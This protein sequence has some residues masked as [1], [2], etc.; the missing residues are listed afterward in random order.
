MFNFKRNL[1]IFA[2]VLLILFVVL[3]TFTPAQRAD[4]QERSV[5]QAEPQ[6]DISSSLTIGAS[7]PIPFQPVPILEEQIAQ[8][9]QESEEQPLR[10][11]L[12]AE[13]AIYSPG[14]PVIITWKLTGGNLA[15]RSSL[16]IIARPPDGVLPVNE[17]DV[18]ETDGSLVIS[19]KADTGAIV[20]KVLE[21]AQLPLNFTYEVVSNGTVLND[22]AI[23]IGAAL[24]TT[25]TGRETKINSSDNR[26]RVDVPSSSLRT[27]LLMDIRTPSP[28]ALRG[29]SLSW[30]PVEIIAVDANSQKNV[31]RFNTP[32]TISIQYDE[33]ELLG[34]D[35]SVLSIFYYDPELNDWFPMETQVDTKNNILTTKSDHLTVFDYKAN[36]WQSAMVPSV[37]AFKTSDFTGAGTYQIN[38]WTPPGPN[39]LQPSLT[40]SYNS[41]V[42]DESSAYTQSSWV[43]MGWDLD[44]GSVTRTL[45]GTD[46]DWADDSV[47]ISVAGVSS[48]LLRISYDGNIG[49]FNTAD[50][51]FIKV[52]SNDAAY[53]Y[54]AWTKDGTKYEF[55]ESTDNNYNQACATINNHT[56]RWNLK[57]VT[58]VHGNTINYTYYTEFKPGCV[59]EVAVYPATITYG[60][61]KYSIEF[62]REARTDYQTS[63][64]T[65]ASRTLYGTSRL[66][67]VLI[68]HNGA[69]VKRYALSYAPN[70]STN[71]YPNFNFSKG[72]KTLTLI[73][74]QEFGSDGTA[75]P[76]VTFTYGDSMHLTQVNNGQGGTVTM[77]YADWQYLDD[78]N[79]DIRTVGTVFQ[80]EDCKNGPGDSPTW[81]QLSGTVRCD[82]SML[83]QV[84]NAPA[85]AS[86]GERAIPQEMI[87]PSARYN[88][89]VNVRSISGTATASW[90]IRDTGSNQTT[91]LSASGITTTGGVQTQQ[92]LT[93][94]VTY[95]PNNVKLRLECS[96]C[97]F[98]SFD[99][100]QYVVLYRVTSRVVTVQ[101]T[102]LSSTYTYQY[103]NASP[104]T[105]D[106]SAAVAAAGSDLATLY[107]KKLREFRGHAMSMVTAPNNLTTATWFWQAD[108]LK[109]RPYN[110]LV[111]ERTF[112]D[113]M[114]AMNSN[115]V[116][117]GGTHTVAME[118]QKDFDYSIKSTNP[119]S[120]WNVSYSRSI[121]SIGSGQMAV[122]HIRLSGNNAQGIVGIAGGRGDAYIIIQNGTARLVSFRSDVTLLSS[123]NFLKDEWYG[124]AFFRSGGTTRARIWQLDNPN[125]Y[126]EATASNVDLTSPAKFYSKVYSGTMFLDSYFEGTPYSQTL[127]TYQGIVQYDE[128]ANNGIPDLTGPKISSS[129]NE[130][131][132]D[133]SITW[134]R[135]DA[136]ENRNYNGDATF[137]GTKQD[138]TYGSYG[139]LAQ[140]VESGN[141]GSGWVNYRKTEY[142]YNPNIT[143]YIVGLPA[144]QTLKD[145][146]NNLLG[147]TL[148]FY[149]YATANTTPPTKGALTMQRTWAG[150]TDYAQTSMTYDDYG[151]LETQSV[152]TEYGTATSS[153]P[154]DSK[155]T[156][157]TEY[158]QLGYNT[159]PVLVRNELG[160]E[161]Q[162]TYNYALGLPLSVKDANNVTTSATYDGFGRMKT[163]T[164]PGDTSPTLSVT[165]HDTRI[166]FQVDLVQQVDASSTIRLS[167]FYDGAGREIQTQTAAAVVNGSAQNIVV[168]TQYNNLGQV[169]KKTVPYTVAANTA[170]SFV[171][172]TF[173]Q[174]YTSMIYDAVGRVDTTTAPNQT[175]VSYSYA[176]LST[177]I[178]DPK[179]NPTTTIMDVWGRTV[180]VDAPAGPDVS[181]QYDVLNRLKFVYRGDYPNG[182][183]F[184]TQIEYD[185]LGRKLWMK[186]PDM[187][188]WEYKYDALGNLISQKDAKLQTTCL[189]YD[190]LN[191]LDGK[192]YSPTASCGTPLNF[193]V[194]FNYDEGTNGTGRRTSMEDVSGSAVWTY[195][196]RGRLSTETKTISGA[197]DPFIT[198]WQYNSGDLPIQMNYPDGETVVYAY[199]TDGTLKSLTSQTSSETYLNDMQYDEAG[200]LKLIE[201]GN[202]IIDK[203][204]NYFA[205]NTA[206]MGG[207]LQSTSV[208]STT[209]LQS[210]TYTYDRNGNVDTITDV[211]FGPQIQSF[212]YDALNRIT[213]A[214]ASGGTDGLYS[215]SYTYDSTGRLH[216]KNGVTYTY[217]NAAHKHAVTSLSNGNSY[218][219]DANGNMIFRNVDGQAFDLVYDEENRLTNVTAQ[220]VQVLPTPTP[221]L[222]VTATPS[223]TDT[224]TITN[225]PTFTASPT[226]TDTSTITASPTITDTPAIIDTPTDTPSPTATEPPTATN[227]PL[228]GATNTPYPPSAFVVSKTNDTND[229]ICNADCSL[230]EAIRAANAQA[231]ADLI[232][233]PPGTYNLTI[234]GSDSNATAGDLDIT[235]DLAIVGTGSPADTIVNA[236]GLGDRV[237]EIL[238]GPVSVSNITIQGGT[239]QGAGIRSSNQSLTLDRV[240]ISGNSNSSGDGG[241][242]YIIGGSLTMTNSAIINNSSQYAG[243]MMVDNSTVTLTNVTV[244]GNTALESGGG[245][246]IKNGGSLSLINVTVSNNTTDSDANGSG[247]G[248][249]LHQSVGTLTIKNSIIAGN[250]DLSSSTVRPDCSGTISSNGNNL[251]GNNNGCT[252]SSASGDQIGT[253]NSPINPQLASLQ[254][255]GGNTQTHALQSNSPVIDAGSNSGCPAQ[256]QRGY[257]RDAAC[258]M[259]AFEYGGIALVIG[260]GQATV[261]QDAPLYAGLLTVGQSA[262]HLAAFRPITSLQDPV[263]INIPIA[264]GNDDAEESESGSMYLNSSDLELIRDSDNQK[265]GMRFTGVNIPQG[266][267][268]L[269][270]YVQFTVDKKS[271]EATNLSVQ[272]EAVDNSAAFSSSAKISTR[273][274]T[275]GVGAWTP[276]AWSTVG[277]SGVDQRTPDLSAVLQEVVDRS[278]WSSGNALSIIVTG[279][280]KR[281]A[282]AYDGN[283]SAAPRLVVQYTMDPVSTVTPT[284][285]VETNTPTPTLETDTPTP[286]GSDTPTPTLETGTPTP[287]LETPTLLPTT[288]VPVLSVFA[289]AAFTYDGDGK[290]VKSVMTMTTAVNTTY[291]VG[292]HY[293][294]TGSSVTKYY[295]AGSQRIAMKKD[296]VLNFIIGDHLGSTSLVT[297][298]NG[299]V[300]NETKY[301]AWGETRYSSGAEQTKYQY[302][303]Q[304]SYAS[305]FGLH[306]YNARWYDSSLSRF[307]QADS[308]IPGIGDSQAWDRYSYVLNSPLRYVDPSGHV[309]VA[310]EELWIISIKVNLA[311]SGMPLNYFDA[312]AY[313]SPAQANYT[314]TNTLPAGHFNLCGD[315]SLSMILETATSKVNTL[316]SIHS[317]SPSTRRW[318]DGTSSYELAQQFAGSFPTGWTATGITYGEVSTF[319]SGMTSYSS[320]VSN[321]PDGV[322]N[323][324]STEQLIMLLVGILRNG[325]YVIAGVSQY[326][327]GTAGLANRGANGSVG[328]WVVV[329]GIS[330]EHVRINNPY[331][332]REERYTWQEFY[333]SW[334]YSLVVISPPSVNKGNNKV[335][336]HTPF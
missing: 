263:S 78:V 213:S 239:G 216:T 103:D 212:T 37:E 43:G 261:Q 68:K 45:H 72:G 63:W 174:A 179:N 36:N 128:T 229:G 257:T 31:T 71:I 74:I 291:F 131:F 232:I 215:E 277:Q 310:D 259:G 307:A 304:Y 10:I 189:Y 160:H 300:I 168:D 286:A 35:E 251:V 159:Y 17:K 327:G 112:F 89:K 260:D 126:G 201:Y 156:T 55:T 113:G 227:T 67:E 40:L 70:N 50:Q 287:T 331:A 264:T 293:E 75:L 52:E 15:Q 273:T 133:L 129:R 109:G 104:T 139:N 62:V 242:I 255:N 220:G 217:G 183:Y 231:G 332:N 77:N 1:E 41:Q 192:I 56:W 314:P 258:D 226:I 180:K 66:K 296:G 202:N 165:Y 100:T 149:D 334:R 118:A 206:D 39:G 319:R 218:D 224:P 127:T 278:G 171:S 22:N 155:Q 111:L 99:F 154:T 152:F 294:V 137:V 83:L 141:D 19:P 247:D 93:M 132:K 253:N 181:Y 130:L 80:D 4:A 96:I 90:G 324:S 219:Y 25:S 282:V 302:T 184:T 328:H 81:S 69:T 237:F 65:S 87:K 21:Y 197:Q 211:L 207:L 163:I 153:P 7:S 306:F 2:R 20:W 169:I 301:K 295:Y 173:S 146:D 275:A 172:Q 84:G 280:G 315:I 182:T 13:P 265:V 303:G 58:D 195:D 5:L 73:G 204:F 140:M 44:M 97:F 27:P 333:Q 203:T 262:L 60:N 325:N 234:T 178:T 238:G 323:V 198:S 240:V 270:A 158:D 248:G 134:V 122:A 170:P 281:V 57:K 8:Q 250:Y 88:F 200:R 147:E 222:P 3:G 145:A 241:G 236:A 244:S 115:W 279:T 117:S 321:S 199:N 29:T 271:S 42:V 191:R 274:L 297:D 76:A 256:D 185:V 11:E 85:Q 166:P 330:N 48:Q 252:V 121:G 95:N 272:A 119:N 105:N 143:K 329:T 313:P 108:G 177:T 245:L 320:Y 246:R 210:L 167:R 267:T 120:D 194:D 54:T 30:N 298:A 162:T 106:N 312:N 317:A 336:S 14:K 311:T 233:L 322:S 266:A 208:A 53:S 288:T 223:I 283:A 193:D 196:P 46:Q 188:E 225:T 124:V 9:T 186:D 123:G 276:P 176:D 116:S 269:N 94:P 26:V 326:L 135:M 148:Y 164:A 23:L 38:M 125:N 254:D 243:G 284:P 318:N 228:S 144:R 92:L 86:V 16:S 28:H 335:S 308:I 49:Q 205:W 309:P 268:I 285:T 299:A 51:A 249:G 12:S 221:T 98:R 214:G 157:T 136:V 33:D 150:G 79:T 59:N 175:S 151:N 91:M 82:G 61:G 305:D 24:A 209:T 110:S 64:T 47:S 161:I 289:N 187:G 235:Q 114:E 292:T 290:R 230:R 138:Y 142:E 18:P 32:I 34:W 102:G 190:D 6:E 316:S 101:P 107:S